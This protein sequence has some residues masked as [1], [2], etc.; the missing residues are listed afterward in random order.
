MRRLKVAILWH[1]HQPCYRDPESGIYRLPWVRLRAEKDYLRMARLVE[2][3]PRARVT[4]NLVPILM[5]Q[6]ADYAAGAEDTWMALARRAVG[7][8]LTGEEFAEAAYQFFAINHARILDSFPAYHRL[9]QVLQ[10]SYDRPALLSARFWADAAVWHNLAWYDPEQREADPLLAPLAARGWDF[11]TADLELIFA[12]QRRAAGE[13]IDAYRRL[14]ASGQVELSVSPYYHPILPLL[15]DTCSAG[16]ALPLATLPQQ[17]LHNPGDVLTH[18]RMAVEA[19]RARFGREPVGMWPSEGS[20]SPEIVP[21]VA[22]CGIRWL[23]TD[24][25]ILARSLGRP[26]ERDADNHLHHP[27]VLHQPYRFE[28]GGQSVALFFRDRYLSDE[29][30]FAYKRW[31]SEDAV[32]DLVQRLR[33]TRAR[34][35]DDGMDYVVTLALDGENCWDDYPNNGND[36]LRGLYTALA[37]DP[38]LEMVTFGGYLHGQAEGSLAPLRALWSGSWIGADFSTWI[39]FPKQNQAWDLLAQ[40]STALSEASGHV[41][42][43]PLPLDGPLAQAWRYLMIAEGSDWFWWYCPRNIPPDG[44]FDELFRR[45]LSAAYR[46]AALPVPP[47]VSQPLLTSSGL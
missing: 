12:R 8:Q 28:F 20:V 44:L 11:S 37:D 17:R 25:G 40:A 46:A 6:L 30:G 31:R 36:F 27:E 1:L 4:F 39:G 41:G 38:S 19:H 15:A 10:A 16:R 2:E 13:A 14:A 43:Q 35:P 18:V 21:L 34:L 9:W 29:I 3:E 23:V 22:Q 42:R 7:A 24:E 5:E 47:V 26:I 33:A 45:N 32:A